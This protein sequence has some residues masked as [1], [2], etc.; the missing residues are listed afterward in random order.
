MAQHGRK[1]LLVMLT[2][3]LLCGCM[4]FKKTEP[5]VAY[6]HITFSATREANI[7][8]Q[9]APVPLKI[10]V[11]TLRSDSAFMSADFFALHNKAASTLGDNLLGNEQ[12]FLL[13][14]GESIKISGEKK[15]ERYYIGVIGEFQDLN[16]KTWRL[17]IPIV[18]AKKPPLY[19]FWN[20]QPP[21]QVIKV[22]ANGQ[23]LSVAENSGR[24]K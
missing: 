18:N 19:K 24:E 16:N 17:I 8:K 11:L 12:F 23:G 2:G 10:S 7:N 9:Q 1:A 6:Y 14:G 21:P 22:V 4:S 3:L 15:N 5:E 20:R 13:P